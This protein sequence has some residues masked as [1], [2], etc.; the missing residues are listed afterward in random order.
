M[1]YERLFK[2]YVICDLAGYK[3]GHIGF[4]WRTEAEVYQGRGQ[5]H[6][7]HKRCNSKV[8]LRSFEVDFKYHEAGV[9][10]RALVKV[11]L[12]EECA[13]KLHYRRL[14][15]ERR[16]LRKARKRRGSG[17]EQKEDAT[18]VDS[19][20]GDEGA[21]DADV[22]DPHTRSPSK[23]R[24][25]PSEADKQQLEALAWKGPDPEARTREDDFDD[26]FNDLL[27]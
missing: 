16:R 3:K 21:S 1:G 13:Y 14:K 12:C 22:E 4:R 20:S 23:A 25:G 5:F 17:R 2:E 24:E 15:A 7:G 6:C 8:G 19:G 11:R 18:V 26:Y 9:D 27:C 10:K